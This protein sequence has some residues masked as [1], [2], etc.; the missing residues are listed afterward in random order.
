MSDSHHAQ[1]YALLCLRLAADCRNLAAAVPTLDLR[2]HFL[3]M[4]SMLAELA[5]QPRVE[6]RTFGTQ[7]DPDRTL[8]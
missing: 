5:V 7:A 1:K 4:G 3:R 8:H 2:A 6:T